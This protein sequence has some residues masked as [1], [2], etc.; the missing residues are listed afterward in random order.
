M[1]IYI[2]DAFTLLSIVVFVVAMTLLLDAV[3]N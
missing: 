1:K 3:L 2:V